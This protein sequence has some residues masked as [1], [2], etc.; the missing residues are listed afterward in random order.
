[1]A[2]KSGITAA[3]MTLILE[4]LF[5]A[6]GSPWSA[7]SDLYFGLC[8]A[9]DNAG[10][11]TGEP[12]I[13]TYG[14]ARATDGND[15]DLWNEAGVSGNGIGLDNKAA[16][17]FPQCAGTQWGALDTFFIA[18]HAS[19]TGA[20]ILAWGPLAVEKTITPGDTASFAAGDL[21]IGLTYEQV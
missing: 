15:T 10:N 8:T 14:Y 17:T 19:N 12:E 3:F 6:Q 16:I 2:D 20:A 5:G 13:G 1:M 18:N 9:C 11:V 4:F 7:A 21:D